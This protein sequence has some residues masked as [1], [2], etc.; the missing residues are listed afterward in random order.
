MTQTKR[1]Y[2]A[3][4]I[5][6]NRGKEDS[7]G[8]IVD[9]IKAEITAV[10]GEVTAVEELGNRDFARVTDRKFPGAPYVQ[11]AYSAPATAPGALLERLR[12]N[13]NVYRTFIQAA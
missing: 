5:I 8:Q 6:D 11:I 4:F 10:E 7:L 13:S 2:L 1:N 3:T 9:E 12:L